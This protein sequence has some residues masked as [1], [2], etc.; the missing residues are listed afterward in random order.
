M[1]Q[2]KNTYKGDGGLL[3]P[4]AH[5]VGEP[6]GDGDGLGAAEEDDTSEA[7]LGGVAHDG[8]QVGLAQV[9]TGATEEIVAALVA[10]QRQHLTRDL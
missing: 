6:D 5:G 8:H 4:H 2:K 10:V 3:V 9:I 1:D 7:E